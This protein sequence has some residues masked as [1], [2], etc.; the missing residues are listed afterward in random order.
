M[1]TTNVNMKEDSGNIVFFR[2]ADGE[3]IMTINGTDRKV[4]LPAASG[5]QICGCGVAVGAQA[6]HVSDA[7]VNYGSGDLDSEA[8]IIAA[9]NT[10]NGKLN[11]ILAA[12]EAFRINATS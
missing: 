12:L 11:S 4:T 10:T 7:K 9:L 1:K 8:E 3:I 6:A 2:P 5:L